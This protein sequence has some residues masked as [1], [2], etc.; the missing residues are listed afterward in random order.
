MLDKFYYK[1]LSAEEQQVYYGILYAIQRHALSFKTGNLSRGAS[2]RAMRAVVLDHPEIYD[3]NAF[4][5][6]AQQTQGHQIIPFEYF[7]V[8]QSRLTQE[9]NQLVEKINEKLNDSPS[10]YA[11]YK[12]I[13]DEIA[14]SISYD[15]NVYSEYKRIKA[16]NSNFSKFIQEHGE[17]FSPYGIL[18]NKKG[19]CQGIAKLFK[20]LCNKLMLQCA[21]VEVNDKESQAPHMLNIVEIDGQRAFIDVTHGLMTMQSKCLKNDS[22]PAFINYSLFLRSKRYAE[23]YFEFSDDFENC[24]DESLSFYTKNNTDFSNLTELKQ[25]LCSYRTRNSGPI[26]HIQYTPI[27]PIDKALDKKIKETCDEILLNH[28]ADGKTIAGSCKFGTY[29]GII[30]DTEEH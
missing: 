16:E 21:C 14:N 24:D 22:M 13:Y 15:M 23:Q 8:D 9:L 29:T 26:V 30:Y 12:A 4:T 5:F 6:P 10:D 7:A 3:F 11:K 27:N 20:I 1:R 19:V 18:V 17:A 2:F 28:C 25:Y